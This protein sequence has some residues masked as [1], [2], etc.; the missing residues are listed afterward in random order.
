MPSSAEQQSTVSRLDVI[1]VLRGVAA[2]M[3]LFGHISTATEAPLPV[4]LELLGSYPNMGVYVFFMIS[5]FVVPWSLW[6][7]G[8]TLGGFPRYLLR[9]LVRLDPPYFAMI[10]VGLAIEGL[11]RQGIDGAFPYSITTVV[12]HLGYLAGLAGH[13]W[14]NPVFWTL[15]IEFQFYIVMG[16]AFP[17]LLRFRDW[18][19]RHRQASLTA[20]WHVALILVVL[21]LILTL[22][23]DVFPY[24][25]VTLI[26]Y[27]AY[28]IAGI[29]IF[30]V[31]AFGAPWPLFAAF[32]VF[33]VGIKGFSVD[34]AVVTL[35]GLVIIALPDRLDWVRS[36]W[37]GALASGLGYISY[38]LYLTH[39][40]LVGTITRR[41]TEAGWMSSAAGA[42]G[43]YLAETLLALLVATVFYYLIER[44]AVRWSHRVALR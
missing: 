18:M 27:R 40:A 31:K 38:S 10:A 5:G 28:F 30:A 20:V 21:Q 34:W 29:L 16:L 15:G 8:Y 37:V 9:R 25:N 43:V 42:V 6:G 32:C 44:P 36:S 39:P 17:A 11:R 24:G 22:V 26:Y 7:Q 12:L 2:L 35:L 23:L 4:V 19:A 41:A 1:H 33:S 3:V 13:P 14:I